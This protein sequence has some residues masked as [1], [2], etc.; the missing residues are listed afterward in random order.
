VV[1]RTPALLTPTTTERVLLPSGREEDLPKTTPRFP[2]WQGEF[3]WSTYGGKPILDFRGE[4]LYA[5]F[6]ILGL[7]EADGWSG[8]WVNNV[9]RRPFPRRWTPSPIMILPPSNLLDLLDRIYARSGKRSGAFDVLAWAGESVLFAEAKHGGKDALRSSQMVW[10]EA[11][12]EEGVPLE[13]LLVV[14][15]G[16]GS[17]VEGALRGHTVEGVNH[18]Y[19]VP[20]AP[21]ARPSPRGRVPAITPVDRMGSD[22]EPPGASVTINDGN[23][24]TLRVRGS[25]GTA[26]SREGGGWWR[27]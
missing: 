6:V 3:P 14:E 10:I 24:T 26:V 22:T 8:V 23:A 20:D 11:A 19:L 16:F 5:E 2:K 15:W 21:S 13:S 25:C 1:V 12:L 27:R 9:H 7:L 18:K 4:P 17:E